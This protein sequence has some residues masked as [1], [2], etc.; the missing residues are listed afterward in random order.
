MLLL[1]SNG[2]SSGNMYNKI[3]QCCSR[4]V[5]FSGFARYRSISKVKLL[6]T[7]ALFKNK[8]KMSPAFNCYKDTNTKKIEF[9]GVL[10]RILPNVLQFFQFWVTK[11]VNSIFLLKTSPIISL[12]LLLN[13]ESEGRSTSCSIRHAH[14]TKKS[15]FNSA[16]VLS[17]KKIFICI[18]PLVM[19][20]R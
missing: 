5:N 8:S 18:L 14:S 12:L 2:R 19:L 13:F 1:S 15:D 9:S 10:L 20:K 7:L 4:N 16:A 11:I 17:F 6:N 3:I